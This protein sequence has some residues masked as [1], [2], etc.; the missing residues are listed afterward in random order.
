MLV[1]GGTIDAST[2]TSLVLPNYSDGKFYEFRATFDESGL[3]ILTPVDTAVV[4]P[5]INTVRFVKNQT[6]SKYY[7]LICR[8]GDDGLPYVTLSDIGFN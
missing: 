5:Q 4:N 2:G 7:E 6:D 3:P 8:N 1:Q